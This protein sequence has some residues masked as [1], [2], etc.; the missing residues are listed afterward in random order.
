MDS[1]IGIKGPDFV[2]LASDTVAFSNVFRLSLKDDKIMEVD[3][4]KL[5]GT[6]GDRMQFGE[7]IKCNLNLYRL[8][9]GVQLSTT[10]TANFTRNELAD[11]LRSDPHNV[12]ILVGG[13]TKEEGPKLFWMDELA[14]MGNVNNA[15][16]GYGGL[17]VTGILDKYYKPNITQE[18]ALDIL[19]KCSEELK[20]RFL[21]SQYS[22]FVKIVDCQGVKVLKIENGTAV[23]VMKE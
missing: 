22:L 6:L 10:A 20:T 7:Y 9:N 5:I 18:E 2:V 1:L 21:L 16:H 3:E 14:S 17:L 15:A 13:Y 11:L 4:N 19:I 23:P 8:R 12:N